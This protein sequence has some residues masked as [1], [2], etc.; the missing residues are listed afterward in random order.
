[1]RQCYIPLAQVLTAEM[2]P[3]KVPSTPRRTE[4]QRPTSLGTFGNLS[5]PGNRMGAIISLGLAAVAWLAIPIARPFIL[6]AVGLGAI[7]GSV[8][9][10]KHRG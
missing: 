6:G 2:I 8:L 1:M 5:V 7:I 10:W 9:W 4:G 3:K